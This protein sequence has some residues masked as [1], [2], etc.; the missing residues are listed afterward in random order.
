MMAIFLPH[1]YSLVKYEVGQRRKNLT[2]ARKLYR[3]YHCEV[4]RSA[5]RPSSSAVKGGAELFIRRDVGNSRR[6]TPAGLVLSA[7]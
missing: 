5:L 7:S 4:S 2:V 1:I 6:R 3:L